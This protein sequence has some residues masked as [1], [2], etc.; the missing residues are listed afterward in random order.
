MKKILLLAMVF[1]MAFT[2]LALAGQEWKVYGYSWARYTAE[3]ANPDFDDW[4]S[5]FSIERTYIRLK[6]TD[7]SMG[8]EA[9]ITLDI[10]NE[11]DGQ[12]VSNEDATDSDGDTYSKAS[13][14]VDWA[15]WMKYA[16]VDLTKLPGLKDIEAKLRIGLQKCYFGMIDLW[17]YP[18][19]EKS[20]DDKNKI[21]SSADQGIAIVGRIPGGW[22]TYE[23]GLYNGKGYK[24]EETNT[25]KRYIASLM[26]LPY[27]GVTVR[28]SYLRE[29]TSGLGDPAEGYSA[30]SIV[31]GLASGP[32]SLWSQYLKAK[33]D[34]AGTETSAK[35][36]FSFTGQVDLT[37]K[38]SLLL[39]YDYLNP[40]ILTSAAI[41]SLYV[42]GVN[43]KIADAVLLQ[44]DAQQAQEAG[45]EHET[46]IMAQVKF[47]WS[48]K[49]K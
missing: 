47:G 6:N 18:T 20:F 40:S 24:Y 46:T 43:Y 8:Y 37:E 38:A 17:E 49:L 15:I 35:E 3:Y 42:F 28:G 21:L 45:K 5:G 27:P 9:A 10:N 31:L 14:K 39:R 22:G 33:V 23:A 13:G 32:V 2:G 48:K 7:K 26:V 44:L 4:A 41:K 19:I 12:V 36:G 30:W 34:E 16:Y 29:I 25:E 1:V 11:A